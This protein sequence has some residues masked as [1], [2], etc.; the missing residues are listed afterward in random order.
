MSTTRRTLPRPRAVGRGAAAAVTAALVGAAGLVSAGTT[1]TAATTTTV[2][3]TATTTTAAAAVTPP[4]VNADFDYQIGA[5][6]TPASGVKVVSRDHTASPAAGLY[7]ICYVNAFQAQPGTESEW[8]DLLLRD[9]QGKV[10][11]DPDWDEAF[12]D[13]RT[14]A[15][16]QRIADKVNAWTDDCA[17]KGFNAVEPDNLDSFTRTSL[18]SEANAKAFVKLLSAHAH[19]KGLAIAQ[20]N[21]PQ[22][23]TSRSETGLDFAVAE[24]CGE[25]EECGDYTE[26]YGDNVIAIEYKKAAFDA[27]CTQWGKRLSIVLRDVYVTAPG[28]G[29]Y[30][31]KSC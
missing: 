22:L 15:K 3:G 20:K 2:A 21:T 4:P 23:S 11:Y 1:A 16:R 7:N 28:S 12:L 26:G 5:P 14:A 27:A 30:V 31:R 29:T 17:A 13:I 24:E 19:D 6:Y 8:G 9:A 18:I 10:V 25:W